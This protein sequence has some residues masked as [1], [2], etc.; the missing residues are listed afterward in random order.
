MNIKVLKTL[1]FDKVIDQLKNF[2][3]STLGKERCESLK[4]YDDYEMIIDKQQETAEALSMIYKQGTLPIGIFHDIRPSLHRLKVGSVLGMGDLLKISQVLDVSQRVKHYGQHEENQVI[5]Q[6]DALFESLQ[7]MTQL[8]QLLKR[9]ILSEEEMSDDASSTLNH[10]RRTIKNTNERIRQQLNQLINSQSVRNM[11]QE[12]VITM[13][14]DRYCLPVKQEYR[15]QF[16]GM[17][18]DQSSTGS[19]LFIEPMSVVKLNNEI[20]ELFGKEQEE[21]ERVLAELSAKVSEYLDVLHLNLE[22]LIDLDFIFAKA[23]LAKKLNCSRPEFNQKGII[24]IKKGRHPLLEQDAVVPIDVHLGQNFSMLMITGPN[25][26]GKTV[27]LKTVGLLTIMGQA[28]LHIP[29]FDGSKLAFFEE[30]Y[31]DIG[32]E[33][34]IEQNLSTFSSHMTNIIH[35]LQHASVN[36]L[37]LFDELGAGTD[38]T[39]GAALAMSILQYLHRQKIRTVATTHYSELKVFA[40]SSEGIENASC[41]FDV[42]TLQPTYKL[43]IGIPGKSNA[44]AISKRLGLPDYI[45]DEAKDLITQ[46]DQQFEDLISDLEINKKNIELEKER[47]EN[48]REKAEILKKELEEK[49]DKLASQREQILTEA[50]AEAHKI[51]Q[52]AKQYADE[53]IRKFNKWT[54]SHGGLQ[55]STLEKERQNIRNRLSTLEE[56]LSST[57]KPKKTLKDAPKDLKVGDS[58]FVTSFNQKGTVIQLPNS[59]GEVL[60]QMGIIKTKVHISHITKSNEPSIDATPLKQTGSGKVKMN[61]TS[62]ISPEIDVRGKLVEEALT[63]IDKYIDDA[64]LSH[65]PQ[66]TII[67]GKGTG[68]LRQA[69]HQHLKKLK[70]VKSYRLGNFGEGES[71]VTVV[72]LQ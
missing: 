2:A 68:A 53:S 10:I 69:I 31:A 4:P 28:G 35:I 3:R 60:V 66:I 17:I 24:N 40:L 33:Q 9:C 26:G 15:Q 32:D 11:L 48:Y 61:K 37:V 36:S 18:H 19:T 14:N 23:A 30:V 45:I 55:Q 41:E 64:Y 70:Y 5:K 12:T 46:E 27:T 29:A 54:Q 59:K 34:S 21:I 58:I 51:I 47:A 39:E 49:T 52:E 38:P 44:F 7:P 1:E 22:T 71:G 43:L 16:A 42:Q 72:E 50:K 67:H 56:G 63:T 6:L 65:L 25:T 13:R 62:H 8:N 57:L 20:K